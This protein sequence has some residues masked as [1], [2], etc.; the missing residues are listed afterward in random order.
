M[1]KAAFVTL[2]CKLNYSET[3]TLSRILE[4]DGYLR[5][6]LT[7][8]P[9]LVVVNTCTVTSLASKK[10]R[11]AI[12][13]IHKIAPAAKIVAVGCYAQ[14]KPEDLAEM[15]EVSLVLGT[16]GKFSI[17]KYL[18]KDVEGQVKK[19]FIIP[20]EQD[21]MFS[22]AFSLGDRTRSFL[23]IQD[24]CDYFCAYCTVPFARGRSRSDSITN[25][26]SEATQI[27]RAGV[28]EI[29][30]SGVNIGDFGKN[31]G[32]TL[33]NL[34]KELEQVPGIERLRISSIEPNLLHDEIIEWVAGS[35]IIAPHFH[36]PLQCGSDEL[37]SAMRRRYSTMV[38]SQKVQKIK[39]CMPQACVAADVIV[40]VPGET[41]AIFE[42]S[43]HFLQSLDISYLHVFS[44]S[45]RENTAAAKMNGKVDEKEKKERSERLH[46]LSQKKMDLF[47]QQNMG[48]SHKVLFE[49]VNDG[50]KMHGWTENYICF[51][52]PF[53]TEW[54]NVIKNV[55]IESYSPDG[56]A[57]GRIL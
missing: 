50:G 13:R 19:S 45:E 21:K 3:S 9:D 55:V 27:V 12:H 7:Q 1:K 30:L 42:N 51:E 26:I 16:T 54:V 17:L 43:I 57:Q 37:L 18:D 34:L 35:K 47:K 46:Q 28:K 25:I 22:P 24:G 10:S 41:S 15:E 6:Q 4:G 36:I 44:Y 56:N 33:L 38:F 32:E 40:G 39:E 2:G 52:A 49:S 48:L 53:H 11:Q 5:V 20:A 8:N 23:K 31:T 14:L 29:I